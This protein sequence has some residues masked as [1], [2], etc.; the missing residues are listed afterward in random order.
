MGVDGMQP[1]SDV[2]DHIIGVKVKKI[3]LAEQ[4][5][6]EEEIAT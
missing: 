6:I 3:N 1:A 4:I 2:L 5:V